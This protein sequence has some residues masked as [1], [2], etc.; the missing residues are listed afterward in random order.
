MSERNRSDLT[1][2]ALWARSPSSSKKTKVIDALLSEKLLETSCPIDN[3]GWTLL[4]KA[5]YENNAQ[6]VEVL[7]KHG[8]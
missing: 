1:A 2:S 3:F 5:V 6:L 4:H 7:L 8:I